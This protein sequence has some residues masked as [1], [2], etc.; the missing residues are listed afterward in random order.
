MKPYTQDPIQPSTKPPSCTAAFAGGVSVPQPAPNTHNWSHVHPAQPVQS[1]YV[2]NQY[3]PN[4]YNQQPFDQSAYHQQPPYLKSTYQNEP[5]YGV[6]KYQPQQVNVL[7][8]TSTFRVSR[9]FAPVLSPRTIS[10][11]IQSS[12]PCRAHF[13]QPMWHNSSP[14]RYRTRRSVREREKEE[15]EA[16]RFRI[17]IFIQV[18]IC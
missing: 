5:S 16:I 11:C 2:Q 6:N 3:N 9:E 14:S 10:Q 13:R 4:P 18:S 7:P 1:G 8:H 17:V 15:R 12:L